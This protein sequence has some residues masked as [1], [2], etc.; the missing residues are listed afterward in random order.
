MNKQDFLQELTEGFSGLSKSERMGLL[1]DYKEHI[2]NS[3]AEGNSE[4]QTLEDLGDPQYIIESYFEEKRLDEA[5]H[6]KQKRNRFPLQ[7]GKSVLRIL[8][9]LL[10]GM[11]AV[12]T[13][14]LPLL[15]I[16]NWV[17]Y[18]NFILYQFF[19]LCFSLGIFLLIVSPLRSIWRKIIPKKGEA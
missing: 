6:V 15:Y 17:I 4:Q 16:V 7:W 13:T 12:I 5:L 11:I 9:A 8:V 10:L 1:A 14:V 3:M 2:A 19:L 18:N